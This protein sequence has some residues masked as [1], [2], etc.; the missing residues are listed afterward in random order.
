MEREFTAI[1]QS[2]NPHEREW[3]EEIFG[4]YIDK[5]VVDGR[6]E[7]VMDNAI[8]FD[9]FVYCQDPAYYARFRGKNAY[10]FH[11][12]DDNNEGRYEQNENF[13]GVF[14]TH[15]S[16]EF[17]PKNLM[18]VPVGYS[19][20]SRPTGMTEPASQRKYVW[21]FVGHLG[22]ASRPDV[23]KALLRVEPH[24]LFA[25]D[26]T[27]GIT[28]Q[29]AK[30]AFTPSEYYEFLAQSTFSPCPMGNVNLE[31]YRVYEA[32]ECG[33]IPIVERRPTLYYFRHL[34]G[35][36]PLH[37]V[38]TWTEAQKMIREMLKK[39]G[40][41]DGIASEMHEMVERISGRSTRP[42]LEVFLAENSSRDEAQRADALGLLAAKDS[43]VESDGTGPSSQSF[44][45]EQARATTGRTVC[46]T[47]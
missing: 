20:G 5:H 6:H 21:S 16:S 44:R 46:E 35:D 22:K 41:L 36:H 31:C 38:S 25:T 34:L 9:A 10:L 14:L 30:R 29:P 47:R 45:H 32:L 12:L 23:A 7:M 11:Y 43:D 37:T 26:D 42:G 40:E 28:I 3:I 15:C 27:R 33:S 24:F 1:W 18:S 4:P 39:P 17:N 8:V 19:V 2:P 13:R